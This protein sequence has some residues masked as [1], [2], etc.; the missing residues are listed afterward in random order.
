MF[1][2]CHAE[3]SF[4]LLAQYCPFAHRMPSDVYCQLRILFWSQRIDPA[5]D[6]LSGEAEAGWQ[7]GEVIYMEPAGI[8]EFLLV[9]ME[10]AGE[11]ASLEADHELRG[12]GPGLAIDVG[13]VGNFDA[14]FFGNFA[15]H[16]VLQRFTGFDEASED[17]VALAP[18]GLVGK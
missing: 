11:V 3:D 16:A 7:F 5:I 14:Y 15:A 6:E 2:R 4:Y 17:A 9:G 18:A 12:E 1:L 10:L 13:D 8:V